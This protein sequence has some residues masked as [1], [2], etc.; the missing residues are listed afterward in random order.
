MKGR[1]QLNFRSLFG[2]KK[3]MDPYRSVMYAFLFNI[4]TD[5]L[6]RGKCN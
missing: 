3:S 1:P 6:E 5:D 2:R 4:F